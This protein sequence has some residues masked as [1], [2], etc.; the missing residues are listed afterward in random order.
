MKVICCC[1]SRYNLIPPPPHPDREQVKAV[2]RRARVLTEEYLKKASDVD[3]VYGGVAES[4]GKGSKEAAGIWGSEGAYVWSIWCGKKQLHE[5]VHHL[6]NRR[7]KAQGLQQG[8]ESVKGEL[9]VLVGQVRRMLSITAV[10]A[11]AEC[12][13]SRLRHVGVGLVQHIVGG[14]GQ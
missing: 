11:Q 14:R 3:R 9:G 2:D 7:L 13:L 8:R 4:S 1:P 5:L 10:R 6:A 12:L